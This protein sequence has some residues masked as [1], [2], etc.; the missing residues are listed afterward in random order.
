MLREAGRLVVEI[1]HREM[2]YNRARERTRDKGM[3]RIRR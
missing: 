1:A 3:C 2:D